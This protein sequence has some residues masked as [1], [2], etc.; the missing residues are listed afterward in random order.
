MEI[1]EEIL[2][3][4]ADEL[5]LYELCIKFDPDMKIID[6]HACGCTGP[7][8]PNECRCRRRRRLVKEF[9]NIMKG[10]Q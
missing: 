4:V 7:P 10:I 8:P 3:S 5:K 9:M 6:V 1:D 2:K